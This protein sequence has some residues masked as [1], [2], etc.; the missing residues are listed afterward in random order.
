MKKHKLLLLSLIIILTTS[1]C[2]SGSKA[3]NP[4]PQTVPLENPVSASPTENGAENPISHN[5]GTTVDLS[6]LGETQRIEEGGF[7]FRPIEEYDLEK[8]GGMVTMLA[9]GADPETGPVLQL[10]GWK[11]ENETTN[12]DLYNQLK[13]ETFMQVSAPM[14]AQFGG[15][16]GLIADITGD[17]NGNSM[18]GRIAMA[19]VTPHQQ[20][21]NVRRAA[22]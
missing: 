15:S 20:F 10:M 19:M 12:E 18:Q 3:G 4:E 11:T 21:V 14:A 1:A 2:G 17:N 5:S 16:Q 8:F 13:N 22:I 6:M 9:P 7:A